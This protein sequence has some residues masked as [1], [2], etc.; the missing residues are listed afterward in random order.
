MA[1]DGNAEEGEV[2]GRVE[3]R[4]EVGKG[5]GRGGREEEGRG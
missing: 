3:G 2:K 1:G 5:G 4:G